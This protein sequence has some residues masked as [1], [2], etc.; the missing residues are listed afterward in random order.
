MYQ[1]KNN[2]MVHLINESTLMI[3]SSYQDFATVIRNE[4]I[5]NEAI[6]DLYE[7]Q[8]VYNIGI[9]FPVII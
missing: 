8:N 9:L 1:R 2:E 4:V 7:Y 5:K 6:T 3:A